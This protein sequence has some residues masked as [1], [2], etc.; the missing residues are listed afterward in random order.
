LDSR[1]R[2]LGDLIGI[3][4]PIGLAAEGKPQRNAS[5]SPQRLTLN[6][7]PALHRRRRHQ[8][9]LYLGVRLMTIQETALAA[10][11][12]RADAYYK[13]AAEGRSNSAERAE[14]QSAIESYITT[15][16][17][18][19]GQGGHMATKSLQSHLEANESFRQLK[20]TGR[21]SAVLR[22]EGADA[23]ALLQRKDAM[24]GSAFGYQT[25]GVLQMER[26]PGITPE[27]RPVLRVEDLL[28]H[29]PTA[30]GIVDF[31]RVSTPMTP[32]SP[33]VE[34]AV[35]YED[36]L[37]LTSVSEKIRTIAAWCGASK[38]LLEDLGE[39]AHFLE[40]SL[41][42]RVNQAVEIQ[43]LSGDSTGENL[44]GLIPA[45]TPFNSSLLNGA[46]GWSKI[47]ILGRA[48][49][50]IQAANEITPTFAVVH[51]N[52]LWSM[53]LLKDAFS[54]YILGPPAMVAPARI[55]D[56]DVV[57][58]TNITAGTFLVGSGSPIASEVRDRSELIF[59][60]AR[61]HSDWFS[62]NLIACRAERRMCLLIRRPGS[63]VSG[64]FSSSPST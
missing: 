59:E 22:L 32:A 61:E 2:R 64:T 50:Q 49:E 44:S 42:Y 1:L 62:R 19:A 27:P 30:L 28:Y 57:A 48:V 43:I 36:E 17:A 52:D 46:A 13:A 51:P 8:S 54:R 63:Y 11:K 15:K 5:G 60:I 37:G 56:L 9:K 4:T 23:D 20:Q 12:K 10:L 47:D 45:A 7:I 18:T 24:T 16:G 58:T 35:K 33:Q 40:T 26:A 38:Q 53:R 14:L 21:G 31:A 6:G 55:F 25:T 41:T 39:L 34:A 3:N 29:R